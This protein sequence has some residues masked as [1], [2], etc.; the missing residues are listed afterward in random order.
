MKYWYVEALRIRF[1]SIF[2]HVRR[3][4]HDG[5]IWHFPCV[6]LQDTT[7]YV[8]YV[9]KDPVNRRGRCPF[10][11][12]L[13]VPHVSPSTCLL[14]VSGLRQR[15]TSWSV[16]TVWPRTSSAPSARPS[17]S[18]SSSTCS[19]LQASYRPRMTGELWTTHLAIAWS[20]GKRNDYCTANIKS[21]YL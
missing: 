16:P 5:I 15:V 19:V 1:K 13:T 4:H 2:I 20:K 17:T 8:A 9:A 21:C 7:D 11:S 12:R 14:N 10:L 18:A 3:W 6:F